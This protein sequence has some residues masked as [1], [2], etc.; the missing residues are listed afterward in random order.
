[1][2]DS[3]ALAAGQ[4]SLN[5]WQESGMRFWVSSNAIPRWLIMFRRKRLFRPA[6]GCMARCG[7]ND[8]WALAA[9]RRGYPTQD[10]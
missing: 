5:A 7:F 2:A 4:L 6:S 3:L 1:M 9:I 10:A 8:H